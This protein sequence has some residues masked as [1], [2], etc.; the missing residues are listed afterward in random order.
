[1]AQ[2]ERGSQFSIAMERLKSI[3][4]KI[5]IIGLSATVKTRMNFPNLLHLR[6][7]SRF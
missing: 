3:A 4:G 7:I 1:M 5:Q 6:E 2:N